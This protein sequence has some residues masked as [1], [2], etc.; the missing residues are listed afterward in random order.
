MRARVVNAKTARLGG[1][2]LVDRTT[3]WGNQ[4]RCGPQDD[5][6]RRE[7]IARHRRDLAH[8]LA[9]SEFRAHLQAELRGE[10]L[11]CHCIP[12]PCH[13]PTLVAASNCGELLD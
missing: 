13:A 3:E 11:G 8:S 9:D 10:V 4:Y 5:T 7:A 1:F 2:V 6:R 12:L